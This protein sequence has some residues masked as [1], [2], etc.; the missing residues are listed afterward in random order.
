MLHSEGQPSTR[1]ALYLIPPYRIAQTVT[2]IHQMLYKQFGLVAA[3]RFPVHAT[4]KGFFKRADGPLAPLVDGLDAVLTM[5]QPFPVH[6]CGL[7]RDPLGVSLDISC[8]GEKPNPEML[9]LRRRVVEAVRPFIAPD[10]DFSEQELDQTFAAHITLAFRDFRP[11]IQ[12]QVLDY[13]QDAPLPSE[14]FLAQTFHLL[15]FSS[16]DWEGPWEQTLTW[17]LLKS[18]QV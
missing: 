4:I 3:D 6:F 8:L 14:P 11:A 13:L 5:Q 12:P 2:S 17:H 18:W 15:E 9:A 10:C 16:R 7:R 1:F